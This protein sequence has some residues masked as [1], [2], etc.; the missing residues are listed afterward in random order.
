MK[1]SK[2]QN[3]NNTKQIQNPKFKTGYYDA[4]LDL[5]FWIYFGFCGI[6]ILDFKSAASRNCIR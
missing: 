2:I 5:G 4:L 1:K 3:P 6:W